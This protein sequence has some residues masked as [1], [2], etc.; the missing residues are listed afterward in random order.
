MGGRI[1]H[2]SILGCLTNV[3]PSLSSNS[4][5]QMPDSRSAAIENEVSRDRIADL[6]NEDLPRR[7]ASR[8]KR[9]ADYQGRIDALM[10]NV[11]GLRLRLKGFLGTS[12]ERRE[13][14]WPQFTVAEKHA[15]WLSAQSMKQV[16]R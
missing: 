12:G 16:F 5:N 6:C 10:N 3:E 7:P 2:G 8:M 11:G 1:S 9:A 14:R 15:D 4:R 13:P